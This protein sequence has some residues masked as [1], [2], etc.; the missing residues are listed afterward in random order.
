MG[1][2]SKLSRSTDL[3]NGM[4]D[5]LGTD[6]GA[7][8]AVDP[9]LEAPRLRRMVLRCSTCTDQDACTRL[10]SANGMLS[11]APDYCRNKTVLDAARGD[12]PST[13]L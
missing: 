5:R 6:L 12:Q 11:E 10:Q 1:L 4:A 9:E 3:V 7:M 8:L 2:I 13:R